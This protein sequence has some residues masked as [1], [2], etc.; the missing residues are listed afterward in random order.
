M[1]LVTPGHEIDSEVSLLYLHSPVSFSISRPVS[2]KK[3][4]T[5][6]RLHVNVN[7]N[8]AFD[9]G[10]LVDLQMNIFHTLLLVM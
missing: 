2:H 8:L 3:K 4:L 5:K 1:S 7:L 10:Y 6:K 9:L